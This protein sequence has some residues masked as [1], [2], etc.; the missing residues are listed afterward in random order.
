MLSDPL[1]SPNSVYP[2][3]RQLWCAHR[4]RIA[5][6]IRI[7]RGYGSDTPRIRFQAVLPTGLDPSIKY[8]WANLDSAHEMKMAQPASHSPTSDPWPTPLPP[9]ARSRTAPHPDSRNPTSTDDLAATASVERRPAAGQIPAPYRLQ[10]CSLA[11]SS[12]PG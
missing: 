5:Y 10:G 11:P 4:I 7:G 8:V 1:R 3:L 9:H 12:S 6:P 2:A